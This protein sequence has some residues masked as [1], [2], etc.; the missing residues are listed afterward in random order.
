MIELTSLE[1]QY[2]MAR[3]LE[4]VG[5]ISVAQICEEF[6]ISPATARRDLDALADTEGIQRV[7]GGAVLLRRATP[8]Q[9]ILSRS[10][11]QDMEKERIGRAAAAL[12]Q[13]G[14]TV[15]LGS[16]TTVLRVAHHLIDRQLT[17]V[18]NS[19]PVINLMADRANITLV[20]LGGMFR[21]SELSFIGHIAEQALLEVRAD[22]VVIGTRA[23]S[24]EQGMTND[25]L[26]ETL[27]DR[28]IIKIGRE[29]VVVADHT[30]C[31][32]VSTAFLAPLE[33]IH[34]LVTDLSTDAEFLAAIE[35]RGIQVVAA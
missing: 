27:T 23:L 22:R 35:A 1:R 9:P 5:R 17:I 29:V 4:R 26:A 12:V 20:A 13:D 10:H 15:F 30:K 16:G 28:A 33:A 14:E 21:S 18:T 34:T 3:T 6:G 24:L 31:G 32:V 7:H 25:Y 2:Q 8:E 19:L 11:E